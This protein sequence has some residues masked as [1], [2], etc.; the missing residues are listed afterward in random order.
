MNDYL[1]V[2]TVNMLRSP[3]A[4][5]VARMM[6]HSADSA[7]TDAIAVRP[8]TLEA[9]E[10][11]ERI[12]CM[13]SDHATKVLDLAPHRGP[14]VDIWHIPDDFDYCQPA[15]VDAIRARLSPTTGGKP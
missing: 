7:G 12:V 5:H 11:A 10:R 4:E 15:L 2:C 14:D 1:F 3:T 8:L 9:I 13:D 6:G